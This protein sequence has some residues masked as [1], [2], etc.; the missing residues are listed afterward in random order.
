LKQFS[1]LQPD[2]QLGC[3]T[4]K[5]RAAAFPVQQH[6][7]PQ[8]ATAS[9]NKEENGGARTSPLR[10]LPVTADVLFFLAVPYQLAYVSM[11]FLPRLFSA[12]HVLPLLVV[13]YFALENLQEVCL[14]LRTLFP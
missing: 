11:Y 13:D 2:R 8:P 1:N 14:C 10:R 7:Q 6:S 5:L 4:L 12:D 3:Q 9:P